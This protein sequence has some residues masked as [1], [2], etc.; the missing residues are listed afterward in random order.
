QKHSV[1]TKNSHPKHYSRTS[2][3][4][5][6]LAYMLWKCTFLILFYTR[7]VPRED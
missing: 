7:S 1:P 4:R 6:I 2:L 3:R 5:T